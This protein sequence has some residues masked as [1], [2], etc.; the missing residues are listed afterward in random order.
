M[1]KQ[2]MDC[3]AISEIIEL[4]LSDAVSF[5]HIRVV[6]G[7]AP[8]AVKALMRSELKPGSYRAWRKR[9]RQFSDRRAVYK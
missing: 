5:D 6:H 8:D 4:A 9:V 1:H 3:A 7:L 2:D